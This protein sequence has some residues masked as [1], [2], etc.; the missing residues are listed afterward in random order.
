MD[1]DN[2][3][4]GANGANGVKDVMIAHVESDVTAWRTPEGNTLLVLRIPKSWVFEGVGLV[5]EVLEEF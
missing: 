4:N 5:V 1:E 2:G 3:A